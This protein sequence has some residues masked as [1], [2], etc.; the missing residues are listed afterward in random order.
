[1]GGGG[2]GRG[3]KIPNLQ[4]S[5]IHALVIGNRTPP[6]SAPGRRKAHVGICKYLDD[7]PTL[8]ERGNSLL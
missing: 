1:M 6:S 4:V 2:G 8:L 5:Y 7:L 3:M